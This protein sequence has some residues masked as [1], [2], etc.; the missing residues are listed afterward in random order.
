MWNK[1]FIKVEYNATENFSL[2]GLDTHATT[3]FSTGEL[4]SKAMSRER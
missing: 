1:L 4:R 2:N 3:G